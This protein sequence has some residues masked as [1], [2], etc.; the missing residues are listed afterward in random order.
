MKRRVVI[1]GVGVVAP[2]GLKANELWE[3]LLSGRPGCT[4]ITRF[5]TTEYPTK[6]ASEVKNFNAEDH[7][8]RKQVR[9][10]D[11]SQQY[12]MVA[13]KEA[14]EDSGFISNGH[15]PERAGAIIGSG[16]GGIETFAQQYEILMKKGP[17]RISP[18]F[19]PM[20]ISDMTAGLVSMKYDLR[21]ANYA[22]VSACA[23]SAH[24]L[25]NAFRVIQSGEADVMVTGGA[26]A[27]IIPIAF[28]GFCQQKAMSTNNSNPEKA[29]RPFDGKRDGFVMGEGAAILVL[30]E[31]EHALKRGSKI[32]AELVGYGMSGDAYHVTAPEPGGRG[33]TLAMKAAMEDAR[34]KTED[35]NYINAHGTATELGDISETRAIKAV[36]GEHAYKIVVNAT[37]SLIGHLLGAAGAVETVVTALSIRDGKIHPSVNLEYPDPE[38]DLDYNPNQARELDVKYALTNS[39]GFGG[40]NVTL[41]LKKYEQNS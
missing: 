25:G 37:K 27:A 38:C 29:S 22:T 10:L 41:I 30:E 12:A 31:L 1:T 9:R 13:T 36:F 18:F 11:I 17:S 7:F 35:V 40:H 23:S 34:I 24:A 8:D 14:I 21:G 39:F 4:E 3:S 6:I 26:E 5:D 28:A 20:M 15:N 19:I 2:T 33:A 16:I 32:Y